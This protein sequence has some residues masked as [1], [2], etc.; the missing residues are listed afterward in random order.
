MKFTIDK[1]N[2]DFIEISNESISFKFKDIGEDEFFGDKKG[3]IDISDLISYIFSKKNEDTL[4][5]EIK[6]KG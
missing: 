4:I 6:E 1:T 5:L 3:K 2:D